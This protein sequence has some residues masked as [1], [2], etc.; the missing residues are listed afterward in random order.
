MERES[1]ARVILVEK[2][3]DDCGEGTMESTGQDYEI[4]LNKFVYEHRCTKCTEKHTY[5]TKY[6]FPRFEKQ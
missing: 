2:I 6:P 5:E 1:E 3:C 4:G